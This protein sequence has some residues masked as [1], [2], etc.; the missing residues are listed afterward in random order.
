MTFSAFMCKRISF[1]RKPHAYRPVESLHFQFWLDFK[2]VHGFC[3]LAGYSDL[4]RFHRQCRSG[5]KYKIR[6]PATDGS[7][8]FQRILRVQTN[9]VEQLVLHMPLLWIAAFAMGDMF[10][11]SF[12][13]VWVLGRILYARGY[14]RKAK[15]R[16][17]GSVI[18]IIVNAILFAGA[19]AGTIASF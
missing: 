12:G 10:A 15:R 3:L 14:Y 17:K 18:G 13:A 7:E 5:I 1:L 8:A 6:A 11:A 9:T 16:T 2:A 4:L 19:A